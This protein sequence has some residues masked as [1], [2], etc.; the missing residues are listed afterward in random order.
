MDVN[1]GKFY[2]QSYLKSGSLQ[3]AHR[4]RT[5]SEPKVKNNVNQFIR[6]GEWVFY[7]QPVICNDVMS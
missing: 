2:N 3:Y 5:V 7:Y 1:F 6:P 4:G